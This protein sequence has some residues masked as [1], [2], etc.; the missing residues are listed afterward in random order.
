M[1]GN[2]SEIEL[3]SFFEPGCEKKSDVLM[4]PSLEQEELLPLVLRAAP[5]E[6]QQLGCAGRGAPLGP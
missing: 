4:E 2:D 3:S 6:H 1:Q 5:G